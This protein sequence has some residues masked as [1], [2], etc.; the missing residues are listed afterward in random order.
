LVRQL[1]LPAE[2]SRVAPPPRLY[3]FTRFFKGFER[4][5]AVRE[6]F[7]EQTAAMLGNLKVEFVSNRFIY[8]AVSHKDAHLIVSSWQLEN[9]DFRTLYLD[10][11]HE[12]YH[13]WQFMH[14]KE[15]FIRGYER[16]VRK[17]AAYF[18]NPIEVAAYRHTVAEA[19]RIGMTDDEIAEYLKVPWSSPDRV[20]A[21]LEK[22]GQRGARRAKP[23][24]I[25]SSVTI[26]KRVP[27]ALSPFTD[28]FK[29]F[30]SVPGVRRLFG[31]A[32]EGVL[33]GLKVEHTSYPLGYVGM[34]FEDGH[35]LVNS[36]HLV[37]SDLSVF[38]LDIFFY[39]QT[40]SQFLEGRWELT[41]FFADGSIMREG[42]SFREYA[43]RM[44]GFDGFD[45]FATAAAKVKDFSFFDSPIGLEAYKA[46]VDEGR[47]IGMT[48]AELEEYVFLPSVGMTRSLHKRF[49]RN[50]GI[51]QHAR[52]SHQKRRGSA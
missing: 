23:A 12:L 28:Y 11:V 30:E 37:S 9:S 47:R 2:I 8:M 24:R 41:G 32:A 44:V 16:L 5:P 34:S 18:G 29:G 45:A 48:E 25:P 51:G 14:E 15:A 1:E 19:E 10:F 33:A 7:G 22:T 13:V 46:T 50:L 6:L 26:S 36:W 4:V 43:A 49:V 40:V 42:P 35:L 20:K 38:Y 21:F 17:P 27:I 39:L 52:N 31:D 3:P